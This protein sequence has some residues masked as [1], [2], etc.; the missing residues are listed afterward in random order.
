MT[1]VEIRCAAPGCGRLLGTVEAAPSDWRG[2]V[3]VPQCPRHGWHTPGASLGDL[4]R[5]LGTRYGD[6]W[7]PV[8]ERY[9]RI[10]YSELRPAIEAAW[11]ASRP[12]VFTV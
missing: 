2:A 10:R 8:V 3:T 6:D 1:L 5:Q 11:R 9:R 12:S 4:R 7:P